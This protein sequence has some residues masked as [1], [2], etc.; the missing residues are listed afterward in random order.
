MADTGKPAPHTP[1]PQYA[2]TV[3]AGYRASN[4]V[5][6]RVWIYIVAGHLFAAF[7][8]LLFYVGSHQG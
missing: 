4:R 7:L 8:F 2:E 6:I 3:D 1:V 5:W